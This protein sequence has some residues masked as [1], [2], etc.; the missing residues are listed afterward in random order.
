MSINIIRVL[1]LVCGWNIVQA[2]SPVEKLQGYYFRSTQE[3][4]FNKTIKPWRYQFTPG[5][6]SLGA[7]GQIIFWRTEGVLDPVAKAYWNP[8][9][10]LTVYPQSSIEAVEALA[11]S[12][13]AG[14]TCDSLNKGGSVFRIGQ[15]VL[16]SHTSCV[17]CAS[18][19]NID[20]CRKIVQ[21]ILEAIPDKT[22]PNWKAILK[23]L[24]IDKAR[25][26]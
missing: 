1:L 10:T 17:Q 21:H 2:Q 26:K 14:S 24:V 3:T 5:I 18:A 7:L 15:F 19:A 6:D 25:F 8:A 20:Y 23:Q 13:Y 9:I 16:L 22:N 11:R 4:Y 12:I